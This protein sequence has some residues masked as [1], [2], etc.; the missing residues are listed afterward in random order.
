MADGREIGI[1]EDRSSDGEDGDFERGYGSKDL[2]CTER[3][4]NAAW[5]A[6][7]AEAVRDPAI[8]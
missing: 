2:C 8:A 4:L 3:Q 5:A 7:D 6:A 1:F